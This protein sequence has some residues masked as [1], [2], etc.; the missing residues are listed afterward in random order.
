MLITNVLIIFFFA[1]KIP[2]VKNHQIA[3]V[4]SK[5]FKARE[6]N[7]ILEQFMRVLK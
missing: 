7:L 2:M 5:N 4:C 1:K 6:S 3:V